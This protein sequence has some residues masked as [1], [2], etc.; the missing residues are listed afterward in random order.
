MTKY[1]NKIL[2]NEFRNF[3]PRYVLFFLSS[4]IWGGNLTHEYL[5]TISFK[6]KIT[7]R[8]LHTCVKICLISAKYW[9]I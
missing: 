6:L 1:V 3:S 5:C 4:L 7:H 9:D 2:V 8:S